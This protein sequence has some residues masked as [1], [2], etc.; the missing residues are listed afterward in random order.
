MA[1]TVA[2]GGSDAVLSN[3]TQSLVLAP[4]AIHSSLSD[5]EAVSLLR[6]LLSV[7]NRCTLLPFSHCLT[8]LPLPQGP[9]GLESLV[10][11]LHSLA[12]SPHS[13]RASFS[14]QSL[15]PFLVAQYHP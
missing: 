2:D 13:S 5:L 3:R 6:F 7:V 14:S 9:H 4:R 11:F 1:T 15:S 12:S 10:T 8:H